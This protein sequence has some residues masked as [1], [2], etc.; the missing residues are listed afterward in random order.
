[1]G[2]EKSRGKSE[3]TPWEKPQRPSNYLITLLRR[4]QKFRSFWIMGNCPQRKAME[5][6]GRSQKLGHMAM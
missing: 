6:D 2:K 5:A 4:L 3:G 1:M